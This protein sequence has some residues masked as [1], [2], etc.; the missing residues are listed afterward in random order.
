MA[1]LDPIALSAPLQHEHALQPAFVRLAS[2]LYA[3]TLFVSALL[4]FAV[5]PMF[6]KM[7]LPRLGG[8]PA[9]WSVAMVF[10][11]AALLIGYAYAHLLARMLRP[12]HAAFVHLAMLASAADRDRTRFCSAAGKRG[13]A[14]ALRPYRGIDRSS[15]RSARG[16]RTPAAELVRNHRPSPGA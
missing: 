5:Q 10:F 8:A 2:A 7:I 9:V 11:Q 16:E 4:L 12:L 6:T 13:C 15:V 1:S 3:G 14:L